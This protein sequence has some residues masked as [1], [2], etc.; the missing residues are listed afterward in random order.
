[1]KVEWKRMGRGGAKYSLSKSFDADV[2]RWKH[3]FDGSG[4]AA[5]PPSSGDSE[6][7]TEVW[8]SAI[9]RVGVRLG[10]YAGAL[11]IRRFVVALAGEH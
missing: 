6:S 5:R 3:D 8:Y 9:D 11:I 1:M 2:T 10:G 7:G 4:S